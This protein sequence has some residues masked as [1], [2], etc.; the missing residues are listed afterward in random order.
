MENRQIIKI[1]VPLSLTLEHRMLCISEQTSSR[2]KFRLLA[3]RSR[4]W[5]NLPTAL[6]M[7]TQSIVARNVLAL[8]ANKSK[9]I[10]RKKHGGE[11]EKE[12]AGCTLSHI[13]DAPVGIENPRW[14]GPTPFSPS[15][16]SFL[17]FHLCPGV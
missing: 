4:L 1:F 14:N 7:N 16:T 8:R 6:S 13:A 12:S 10:V 2:E 17:P 15:P 11:A 3:S 5:K 9:H